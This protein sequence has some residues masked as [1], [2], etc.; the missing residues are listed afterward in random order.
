MAHHHHP[1]YPEEKDVVACFHQRQWI[2]TLKV[3]MLF[4]KNII[5]FRAKKILKV[6]REKI[7]DFFSFLLGIVEN[8]FMMKASM[9]LGV[10]L[11]I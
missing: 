8:A 1:G 11:M 4:N 5:A 9:F 10:F 3:R 6:Y 2:I 7:M